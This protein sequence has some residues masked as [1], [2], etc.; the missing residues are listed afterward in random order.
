MIAAPASCV[1]FGLRCI[2][3][4]RGKDGIGANL[5]WRHIEGHLTNF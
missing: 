1:M 2:G 4:W 3:R 5:A